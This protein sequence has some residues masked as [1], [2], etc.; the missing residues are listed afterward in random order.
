MAV[1]VTVAR[2]ATAIPASTV[3]SIAAIWAEVSA[4]A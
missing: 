2:S 4:A 1:V 3:A